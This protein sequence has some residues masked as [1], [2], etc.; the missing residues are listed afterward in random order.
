MEHLAQF[1]AFH[2]LISITGGLGLGEA[3][4]LYYLSAQLATSS[5]PFRKRPRRRWVVAG[6][7]AASPYRKL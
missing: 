2:L 4:I 5:S 6:E 7:R 1:L 3:K